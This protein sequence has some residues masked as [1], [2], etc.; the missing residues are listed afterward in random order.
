[1]YVECLRACIIRK[2]INSRLFVT[3]SE[4]TMVFSILKV[5][6]LFFHFHLFVENFVLYQYAQSLLFLMTN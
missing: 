2:Y 4:I 1:M 3:K 5:V 6:E